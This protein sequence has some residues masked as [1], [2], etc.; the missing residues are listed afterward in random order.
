MS[1]AFLYRMLSTILELILHEL[2]LQA[3]GED[4]VTL[5]RIF[6]RIRSISS[7]AGPGT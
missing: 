7:A 1:Y 6:T 3:E 4:V 5:L 2:L